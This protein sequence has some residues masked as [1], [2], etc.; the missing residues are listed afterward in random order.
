M[1]LHTTTYNAFKEP[2]MTATP[3]MTAEML[4]IQAEIDEAKMRAKSAVDAEDPT[5]AIA[6]ARALRSA[7]W[8]KQRQEQMESGR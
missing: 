1:L 5:M 4:A 2:P 3:T 7:L 6:F 8:R